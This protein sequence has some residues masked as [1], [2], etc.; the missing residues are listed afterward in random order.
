MNKIPEKLKVRVG[1]KFEF[2]FGKGKGIVEVLS[3]G[4]FGAVCFIDRV[5]CMMWDTYQR[6]VRLL[7]KSGDYKRVVQGGN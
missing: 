7:I 2:E 1:D 4:P 3:V 6:Q 5:K